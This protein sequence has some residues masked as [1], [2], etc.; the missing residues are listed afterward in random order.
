MLF[1]NQ[2][3]CGFSKGVRIV[4]FGGFPVAEHRQR[5]FGSGSA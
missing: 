5:I 3:E 2:S 1:P 4:V